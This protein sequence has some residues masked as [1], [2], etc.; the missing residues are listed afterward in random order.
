MNVTGNTGSS[1][2]ESD[3]VIEEITHGQSRQFSI[4]LEISSDSDFEDFSA[5][6][7]LL[8]L[9]NS[10]VHRGASR[11]CVRGRG[12]GRALPRGRGRVSLIDPGEGTSRG[13]VEPTSKP[14]NK[15]NNKQ[16]N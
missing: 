12:I 11:G 7:N 15:Q 5:E 6:G 10:R 2:D 8:Q 9:R 16:A 13:P 4:P 14:T 1:S 3:I